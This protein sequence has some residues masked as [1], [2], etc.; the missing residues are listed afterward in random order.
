VPFS[1]TRRPSAMTAGE[2]CE[3]M[4]TAR[5]DQRV[6][7]NQAQ[8]H[9]TCHDRCSVTR[10]AVVPLSPPKSHGRVTNPRAMHQ[11][12]EI[13]AVLAQRKQAADE[14]SAEIRTGPRTVPTSVMATRLPASASLQG[15]RSVQP[16]G[17]GTVQ[18]V[19]GGP[20]SKITHAPF[21]NTIVLTCTNDPTP[22][23]VQVSG[24]HSHTVFTPE[25]KYNPYTIVG[26][27]FGPA[28]PGNSA[29]ISGP[30]GFKANVNIDLW[31]DN[32][33]TAHLDPWLAGVLD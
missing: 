28:K 29:Y 13:I 1:M 7:V 24:G 33:I 18:D 27:G 25:L 6:G 9:N 19:Q 4:C 22:R 23:I 2:G 15:G 17:P 10:V 31:S 14:E 5:C 16:L 20:S 8:C 11:D 26:C 12:E 32:G 3:K 21:L 30:Y